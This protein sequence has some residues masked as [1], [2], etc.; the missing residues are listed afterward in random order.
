[1][2]GVVGSTRF[3]G[4]FVIRVLQDAGES[5]TWLVRDPERARELAGPG[6][7]IRMCDLVDLPDDLPAMS[8]IV[9]ASHIRFASQ[10][11][12]LCDR[13]GASRAIFVSSTWVHSRFITEQV[14][15][16]RAGEDVVKES[17]LTWTILRPTMIYGPGD[18]NISVLRNRIS[19]CRVFP[20]IGSGE[21]LVQPVF[22]EDVAFAISS[23]ASRRSAEMACLEIC[24][25]EPMTYSQMIDQISASLGKSL[26]K[27]YVPVLAAKSIAW[28]MEKLSTKPGITADQ[29]NR[30]AEDR[31]FA[32]EEAETLLGFDPRP[33]SEG[34]HQ[35]VGS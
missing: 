10:V 1:M 35:A 21:R 8:C 20:V 16:T 5:V 30:M 34:L 12:E 4:R 9:N 25:P 6:V 13:V 19:N 17:D 31:S 18:R 11:L 3:I 2:I 7:S 14:Q 23:A 24:G 32:I 28:A 15:S 29:I 26:V 27:V 22:V 33:F